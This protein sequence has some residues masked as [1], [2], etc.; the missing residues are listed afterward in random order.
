MTTY[1]IHWL[2]KMTEK[3][4]CLNKC[5]RAILNLEG[6]LRNPI[7]RGSV[8]HAGFSLIISKWFWNFL[9]LKRRVLKVICILN[10]YIFFIP[11]AIHPPFYSVLSFFAPSL[12]LF[13]CPRYVSSRRGGGMRYER[14]G[15]ARR[16]IRIKTLKETNLGV[17]QALF[18]P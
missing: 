6:L 9:F 5:T 15:D 1:R 14:D 13:F 12:P 18:G 7:S 11:S 3:H 17:A 8:F 4:L 2:K 10:I 16:K